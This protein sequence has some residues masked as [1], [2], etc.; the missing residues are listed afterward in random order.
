MSPS[1]DKRKPMTIRQQA[2]FIEALARRCVMRDGTVA[3]ETFI[4]LDA[5]DADDL[6]ALADRLH[7][8]GPHENQIRR[9]VVGR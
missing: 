4:M 9:V 6:K 2:E 8:M 5:N 1:S 7:R 3:A